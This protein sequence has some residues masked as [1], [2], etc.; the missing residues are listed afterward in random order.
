MHVSKEVNIKQSNIKQSNNKQRHPTMTVKETTPEAFEEPPKLQSANKEKKESVALNPL[1]TYVTP[2]PLPA[3]ISVADIGIGDCTVQL[4][5]RKDLTSPDRVE[6][7]QRICRLLNTRLNELFPAASIKKPRVVIHA[8]VV[9]ASE[10][11]RSGRFW[12]AELGVG[13]AKLEVRW[14]LASSTDS[15][16]LF[17]GHIHYKTSSAGCGLADMC[18]NDAGDRA[19]DKMTEAVVH[20]I[21][22]KVKAHAKN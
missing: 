19:L 14:V 13:H 17:L 1:P 21:F 9:L 15:E 16:T 7:A 12:A 10:G 3:E 8:V 22:M 18:Q 5:R 6:R 20:D 4:E 2:K 11:S